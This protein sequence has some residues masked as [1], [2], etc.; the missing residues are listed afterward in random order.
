ML[1]PNISFRCRPPLVALEFA[2]KVDRKLS[3]GGSRFGKRLALLVLVPIFILPSLRAFVPG[4][5]LPE[6]MKRHIDPALPEDL[7]RLPTPSIQQCF[8]ATV[9]HF[10]TYGYPPALRYHTRG[11]Q[12]YGIP[13]C[14]PF[15]P[16]NLSSN[17]IFN[18]EPFCLRRVYPVFYCN[19]LDILAILRQQGIEPHPGPMSA[20]RT[21]SLAEASR[22]ISV[23]RR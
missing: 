2:R 16:V 3:L 18:L 9:A 21:I 23:F 20:A 13:I 12:F 17:F 19:H 7:M 1:V 14:Q 15:D 22:R 11:V 6:P 8:T 4:T 10:Y 5:R